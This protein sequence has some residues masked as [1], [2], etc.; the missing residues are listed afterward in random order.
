MNANIFQSHVSDEFKFLVRTI[1][2]FQ[3]FLKEDRIFLGNRFIP[4]EMFH[5]L[6]VKIHFIKFRVTYNY[7]QKFSSSD[8]LN[9]NNA[10]EKFV[11]YHWH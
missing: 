4:F 8:N 9:M 1:K 11:V 2:F 6:V 3:L 5:P 7:A 10:K